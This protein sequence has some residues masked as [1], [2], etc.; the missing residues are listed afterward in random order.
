M[1]FNQSETREPRVCALTRAAGARALYIAPC[2]ELHHSLRTDVVMPRVL[3][4]FCSFATP[5][6]DSLATE[7]RGFSRKKKSKKKNAHANDVKKYCG[8]FVDG[9]GVPP[10]PLLV[11]ALP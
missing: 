11:D 3:F 9:E 10:H 6:G 5:R 7:R 2:R 1:T 4:F 8:S